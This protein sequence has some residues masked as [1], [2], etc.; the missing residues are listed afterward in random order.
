MS[1]CIYWFL[2]GLAVELHHCAAPG[3]W[4]RKVTSL[5]YDDDLLSLTE[6][7]ST[8][9]QKSAVRTGSCSAGCFSVGA[10]S[11][12]RKWEVS[13]PTWDVW[14]YG[15]RRIIYGE[16]HKKDIIIN[17]RTS[18][19]DINFILQSHHIATQLWN[20]TNLV[21]SYL[22]SVKIFN[23]QALFPKTWV[24]LEPFW[25][26]DEHTAASENTRKWRK[27]LQ[28]ADNTKSEKQV[29]LSLLRKRDRSACFE[30]KMNFCTW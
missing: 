26:R 8:T 30:Q 13:V 5:F 9:T 25:L 7:N 24:L 17:M 18:P 14:A 21:H 19:P 22:M 16:L 4:E 12:V 23:I 27:H 29:I 2:N 11:S 15:E 20:Y 10:L 6:Q 28:H 3:L 1:D